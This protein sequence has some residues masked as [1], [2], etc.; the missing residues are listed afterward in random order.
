[1]W[2]SELI[3]QYVAD[4]QEY[5]GRFDGSLESLSLIEPFLEHEREKLAGHPDQEKRLDFVTVCVG[6]Y[7]G[8]VLRA[9]VGGEWR[10]L[11]GFAPTL[12]GP[13]CTI[14]PIGRVTKF[15]E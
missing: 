9:A 11:E 14:S 1:M 5:C 2:T 4:L 10:F 13:G 12:E 8:E 3:A 6:A 7:F 15:L